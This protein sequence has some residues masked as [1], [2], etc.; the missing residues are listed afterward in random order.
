MKEGVLFAAASRVSADTV[1][2]HARVSFEPEHPTWSTTKS[3]VPWS[4]VMSP[5]GTEEP[6]L[7]MPARNKPS[8]SP[9]LANR[10]KNTEM[11]PALSPQ[12]RGGEDHV[13][14][15]EDVSLTW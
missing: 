6:E 8:V 11:D 1:R 15:K 3:Y 2:R 5:V 9:P 14:I 10:C 4:S 7:M 12:L 13:K